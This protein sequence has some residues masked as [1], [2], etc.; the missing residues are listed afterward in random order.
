MSE[1]RESY[2]IKGQNG[3]GTCVTLSEIYAGLFVGRKFMEREKLKRFFHQLKDAGIRYA[4]VGG[5]AMAHHAIPRMTQDVDIIV[6]PDDIAKVHEIFGQEYKGG[7][8]IASVYEIEGM[9]VDVLPAR[10][11]VQ[12]AALES[13]VEAQID[14]VTVKVASVREFIVLKLIAIAERTDPVKRGQDEVDVMGLLQYNREKISRGDIACICRVILAM[15]Y[16]PELTRK[17]LAIVNWFNEMLDL[18]N[19]SERRF[20]LDSSHNNALREGPPTPAD[21]G[22]GASLPIE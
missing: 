6:H 4:I 7:T 8:A 11:A 16:T 19:M 10:L 20:E 21:Y 15:A 9:K 3:I 1:P 12:M 13:A 18:L 17:F 5:I 14:D 22:N 2:L